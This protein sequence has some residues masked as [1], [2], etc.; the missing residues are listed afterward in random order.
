MFPHGV[1]V[2][3]LTLGL[4]LAACW[5]GC[6][7]AGMITFE[8]NGNT[9]ADITATR[10]AFRSA[11]GGG[12]TSGPNGNFGGVR[13]EINWDGV[14]DGFSDPNSLPGNFFNVNSPR[15]VVFSTP[16]TGFLVSANAGGATPALFGFGGDLQAFSAQRLF[17]SAGSNVTDILFFLPG[18]T[19]AATTSAFGAIFVDVETSGETKMEFFD[20]NNALIYSREVLAGANQGLSFTGGVASAGERIARVRITTADNVLISNGLRANEITDFVVMDDFLYATPQSAVPE[21]GTAWLLGIG[22][23]AG[24]VARLRKR[25]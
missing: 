5:S 24:G 18:T 1:I 14:P 13:R 22:L 2:R 11:V 15:G 25:R 9:P 19:T 3:G 8:A 12:T 7:T 17:A 16:G 23:A 20:G 21:P 4:A 6:A 10:D